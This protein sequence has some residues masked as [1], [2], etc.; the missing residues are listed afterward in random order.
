MVGSNRNARGTIEGHGRHLGTTDGRDVQPAGGF[1][2]EQVP[3][4]GGI[5]IVMLG[6]ELDLAATPALRAQ[7]DASAGRRGMVID[8]AAATFIDS[9]ILKELLRANLEL[10]R[11]DTRL[12]LAGIP[13]AV[14]RLLDLTRTAELFTLADDR[15]TALRLLAG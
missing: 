12:V 15:A 14:R 2:V 13:P 5:A 10:A 3:G 7:V 1:T 11:Y 9:S 8:L 6:G 4:D